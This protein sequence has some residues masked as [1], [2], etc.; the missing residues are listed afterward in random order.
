MKKITEENIQSEFVIRCNRELPMTRKLLFHVRNEI[1]ND[2]DFIF[3]N[4]MSKFG[5]T[6]WLSWLK[7]EVDK[8]IKMFA[9][10]QASLGVV[11]GIPDMIFMWKGKAYGIEFKTE[12]GRTHGDQPIVHD[13]WKRNGFDVY[14]C[15]S[16]EQA[17]DIVKQIIH[18]NPIQN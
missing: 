4:I 15:R 14:L 16:S 6:T 12:T 8:R 18:D 2:N 13:I 11:K 3:A 7:K 5:R 1:P 17:F 10:K 9:S